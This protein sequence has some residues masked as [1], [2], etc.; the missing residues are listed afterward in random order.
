MSV[1]DDR[2]TWSDETR[3]EVPVPVVGV[4][5]E[6][7]GTTQQ[8]DAILNITRTTLEVFT[9]TGT[10]LVDES[11]HV[12]GE[13]VSDISFK[14]DLGPDWLELGIGI[15]ADAGL[16]FKVGSSI[17]AIDLLAGEDIS[18]AMARV[19][20]DTYP[21]LSPQDLALAVAGLKEEYDQKLLNLSSLM[22]G[23]D[24]KTLDPFF[25]EVYNT[26][27]L[28]FTDWPKDRFARP[29]QCFLGYTK[30]Q[31]SPTA[32]AEI[33]L[34]QVGD[35]VLA[36]D[37]SADKGRGALVPRRVTR[38]Y[39]DNTTE[40]IRLCWFDGEA[41]ELIATPGHRFLDQFGQFP[42]IGEMARNG[43]AKVVLASGTLT[44]VGAERIAFSA[45]TAHLF[46]R[47][48]AEGLSVGN[49]ALKP[50]EV[51]GW[52]TYNIEV[53]DLHT[54]IA[55][56]VRVHNDSI[57]SFLT[58]DEKAMVVDWRDTDGD[59]NIDY[60]L[61][62]T[63]NSAT[64]IQKT[65]D[66][67]HVVS[68][69]TTSDGNGQIIYTKVVRD[70]QGNIISVEADRRPLE[71]QGI[72]EAIGDSLTPFLTKAII[73]SDANIFETIAANTVIGTL[74]DNVGGVIG[75][76]INRADIDYGSFSLAAHIDVIT[77][78]V[79]ENFGGELA[80]TGI[81]NITSAINQLVMSE[82]FEFIDTDGVPGAIWS[83]VIG[84][85]VNN[86]VSSG[87]DWLV[88]TP[89]FEALFGTNHQLYEQI[90]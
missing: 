17:Q 35:I 58:D 86:I 67:E 39:R 41:K 56:G 47:G 37:A 83:A 42:T 73:G 52:Q 65:L 16:Y 50:V 23:Y 25:S 21:G 28:G 59:G 19:I 51:D 43:S 87:V 69:Q 77:K 54:Y 45:D 71:G 27:C 84:A 31:T 70:H 8:G 85:G 48:V 33:S 18:D 5:I 32:F 89:E 79:F 3:P 10:A 15:N 61:L 46:E 11:G 29:S 66:M 75:A 88:D 6:I 49:A 36:Y 80:I 22:E 2:W 68:E 60:A 44:E 76:L 74:L 13:K 4:S 26:A 62:R 57:F 38:L 53:E 72:G 64:E 78:G 14:V 82:I 40:W 63:P 7:I 20:D 90:N 24:Q 34:I 30:I 9:V 1:V 55:G 81:E 12:H